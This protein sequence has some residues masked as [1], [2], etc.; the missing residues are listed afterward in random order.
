MKQK[1]LKIPFL[2]ELG[3]ARQVWTEYNVGTNGNPSLRALEAQFGTT[4]RNYQGGKQ[5]WSEFRTLAF[6][7]ESRIAAGSSELDAVTQLQGIADEI[8]RRGASRALNW[9]DVIAKVT[10]EIRTTKRSK[11]SRHHSVDPTDIS[12]SIGRDGAAREDV[13]VAPDMH[14]QMADT[15]G[16]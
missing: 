6:Y 4:W 5:R 11:T 16:L 1:V 14:A 10:P 9:K 15:L 12:I 8:G 2:R 3:S 7:I 13:E